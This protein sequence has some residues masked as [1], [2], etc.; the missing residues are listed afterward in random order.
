[1]IDY[2]TISLSEMTEIFGLTETEQA[3]KKFSCKGDPDV[4]NFL[5][6]KAIDYQEGNKGKTFILMDMSLFREEKVPNVAA[7]FTLAQTAI[8]LHDKRDK[9]KK[10]IVGEYPGR[11]K[12]GYFPAYLIGQI[13]RNDRYAHD[14]LSGK[15]II[16][17]AYEAFKR[18]AQ[19]V[20]GKLVVLECREHMYEKVY[21]PLGFSK[22]SDDLN[23]NNLYMLY[24]RVDL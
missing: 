23:E 20:G 10:K 24:K 3:L 21:Q 4:E 16:M 12:L 8:D 22:L 5:F 6:E 1:M 7:Y 9:K 17:E 2:I 18:A 14:D 15:T 11:T 19:I 13:G